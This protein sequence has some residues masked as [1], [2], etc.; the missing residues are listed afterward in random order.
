MSE[1]NNF[2]KIKYSQFGEDGIIEEILKRLNEDLDF[3]CCEFGAWDGKH[4]SNVYNLVKNKNYKAL[5]IEGDSKKF[6]QLKKN[7]K[8]TNAILINKFVNFE[9]ENTLDEILSAN[10]FKKNFDLLSIDIDGNDYHILESLKNYTPKI[11]IIEYNPTIPNE[12]EFVQKKDI[13]TNQGSSAL[14]LTNLAIEKGYYLV[15]STVTNLF[16]IHKDYQNKVTN[17]K[18]YQINEVVD[19]RDYKNFIWIGYDGK[20]FTSKKLNIYWHNVQMD[21]I[22]IIPI[23][24]QKFPPNY[25]FFEKIIFKIYRLIINPEKLKKK[26]FSLFSKK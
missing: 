15:A 12:V 24:L 3:T 5:Y 10:N 11:I 23:F 9:G 8:S 4:L 6:D 25:N 2:K 16:F 26:I 21:E 14:S 7:F 19:D 18:N 17:S 1:L 20:I 22:K 13:K